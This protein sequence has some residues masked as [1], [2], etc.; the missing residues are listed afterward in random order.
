MSCHA[1]YL[2]KSISDFGMFIRYSGGGP[3]W[4]VLPSTRVWRDIKQQTIMGLHSQF[5][6]TLPLGRIPCNFTVY[7]SYLIFIVFILLVLNKTI[8][9][10]SAR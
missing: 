5:L 9:M 7:N 10:C 8:C 1:I 6:G 3:T 2:P 4:S